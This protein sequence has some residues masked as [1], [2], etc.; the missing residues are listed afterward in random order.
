M[1]DSFIRLVEV[2]KGFGNGPVVD[3]VSLD[4]T[5]GE[6]VALL[7]PSGCGKTT[8]LRLIAGLE[9][10]DEGEIW[11]AGERVAT[12]GN[13]LLPP[14]AR[15]IGFVFQ[16]LALWPHMTVEGNLNFV[17]ASA[18][19]KRPERQVRIDEVL[20]LVHALSFAK[21]YPAQLSGGEQQ[22]AAI[23][24]AIVGRPQLLLLD[25]PMSSLDSDLKASLLH[26]LATLQKRLQL[27]TV[28]VTH[29]RQEAEALAHRVVSMNGGRIE[30]DVKAEFSSEQ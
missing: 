24:R 22:R 7:G 23:A 18:R 8:T 17:L 9:T 28:Y 12:I 6:V 5:E 3:R 16:D 30:R 27:T 29:N 20:R 10:P 19:M 1:G 26:E 14:R 4:V 25:E 21:R 13:N 15:G 11:I 2:T